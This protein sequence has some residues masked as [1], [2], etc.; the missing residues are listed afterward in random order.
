MVKAKERT[1]QAFKDSLGRIMTNI[2]M[3]LDVL[4]PRSFDAP[5]LGT[6]IPVD[7]GFHFC[8]N[9]FEMNASEAGHLLIKDIRG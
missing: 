1:R 6:E 7:V 4:R 2:K 9:K 8:Y 3:Y 5:D